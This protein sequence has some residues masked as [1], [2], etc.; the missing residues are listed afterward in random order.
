MTDND[1]TAWPPAPPE[2]KAQAT[3]PAAN[4]IAGWISLSL[5]IVGWAVLMIAGYVYNPPML[6]KVVPDTR[7]FMIK[8]LVFVSCAM[9]V[10]IIT[11]IIGRKS[12]PGAVG[13]AFGLIGLFV[14]SLLLVA[15][16][17]GVY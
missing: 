10:A 17:S 11:G 7:P 16:L 3:K 5:A 2:G 6:A 14:A 1:P 13:L 9:I 8:P 15:F 4:N 12:W